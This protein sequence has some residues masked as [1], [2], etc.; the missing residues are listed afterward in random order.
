MG[1]LGVAFCVVRWAP[2]GGEVGWK[3]VSG[4]KGDIGQKAPLA[5]SWISNSTGREGAKDI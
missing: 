3:Q 4:G 2:W 1:S 5:N